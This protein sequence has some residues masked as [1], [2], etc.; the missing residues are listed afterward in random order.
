LGIGCP[1]E[2]GHAHNGGHHCCGCFHILAFHFYLVA[3]PILDPAILTTPP[4]AIPLSQFLRTA[5]RFLPSKN[6]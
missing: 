4:I 6:R 3:E 1:G 5:A 2:Q